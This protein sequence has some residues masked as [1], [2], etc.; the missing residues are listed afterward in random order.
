[1]L[2]CTGRTAGLG[3]VGDRVSKL[4]RGWEESERGSE[5]EGGEGGGTHTP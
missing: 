5:K 4:G 3:A 2:E 1:M